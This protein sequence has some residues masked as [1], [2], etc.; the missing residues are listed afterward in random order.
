ML[1]AKFDKYSGPRKNTMMERYKFKT[2]VQEDDETADQYVTEL[3]F[4]ANNCNF[5]SHEDE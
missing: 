2:G 3:K 5:V 4:V 1:F